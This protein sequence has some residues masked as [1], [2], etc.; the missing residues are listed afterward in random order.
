MSKLTTLYDNRILNEAKNPYHFE[1][2]EEALVQIQ[3]YNPICGD[4]FDLFI[5]ENTTHFHGFGCTIS[6]ASTSFMLRIIE[7]KENAE[8]LE[9]IT[10]FLNAIDQKTKM[11]ND[12]LK[13]FED[14]SR[15]KG[16]LDCVRLSWLAM[17]NYL[18]DQEE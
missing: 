8:S 5:N 15:F 13:V 14:I 17:K 7:G 9:I 6:K 11:E 10:G 1:K 12:L 3:A 4:R 16:R 18:M 2:R